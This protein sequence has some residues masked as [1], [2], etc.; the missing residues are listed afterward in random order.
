MQEE[1]KTKERL[2]KRVRYETPRVWCFPIEAE[3]GIM[4]ASKT[5]GS[6]PN[7]GGNPGGGGANT[8]GGQE[9][10]LFQSSGP[11]FGG[12]SIGGVPSGGGS[13]SIGGA[14]TVIF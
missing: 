4:A 9:T 14:E 6:G 7:F 13:G 1:Q 8:I 10:G 2:R 3:G 12:G 5:T 11:G